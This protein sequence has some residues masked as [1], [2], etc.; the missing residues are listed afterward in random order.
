MFSPGDLNGWV[1]ALLEQGRAGDAIR[2]FTDNVGYYPDNAYAYDALGEAQLA[3]GQ[4]DAAV[5]SYSRSLELDPENTNA[6]E[7]LAR[8]EAETR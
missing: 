7:V 4:R 1:Y 5:Q 6:R 8:I 2:V 3:A